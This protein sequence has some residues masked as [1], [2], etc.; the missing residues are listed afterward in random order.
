MHGSVWRRVRHSTQTR[1]AT[2]WAVFFLVFFRES[3]SLVESDEV[4]AL[5]RVE[6]MFSPLFPCSLGVFITGEGHVELC[7]RLVFRDPVGLGFPRSDRKVFGVSTRSYRRFLLRNDD[8]LRNS[9]P[10]VSSGLHR[11]LPTVASTSF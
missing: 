9:R 10:M 1:R 11:R 6:I 2:A 5:F 3:S 4:A 8:F 7:L